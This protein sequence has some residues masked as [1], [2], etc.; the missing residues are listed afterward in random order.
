MRTFQ[1]LFVTLIVVLFASITYA[2]A[3]ENTDPLAAGGDGA[4]AVSGYVIT[5]VAY[6]VNEADP[7]RLDSVSFTL[8]AN[9]GMVRIKLVETGSTWYHCNVVS[10]NDWNCATPGAD[11]ASVDQLRVFAASH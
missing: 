11:I 9:A 4:S 8:D 7:T 2:F 6:N 1:I 10:G 3:A 5:D